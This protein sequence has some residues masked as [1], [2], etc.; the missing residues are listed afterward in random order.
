KGWLNKLYRDF[1]GQ[2]KR[3]KVPRGKKVEM[4]SG[5]G[6]IKEIIPGVITSDVVKAE[7]IDMIF[8]AERMPFKNGGVTAFY[9]LNTLHHIK[10][11]EKA[12]AE[13][14]RCLKSGGKV[15]MIEPANT[16]WSRIIYHFHQEVFDPGAD[17]RVDGQ[18]RLADSNIALPWIIFVR[19]RKRFAR[20]FP[21]LKVVKVAPQTPFLYLF[22]GGLSFPQMLPTSLYPILKWLEERLDR[23]RWRLGMFM[24]IELEKI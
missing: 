6:F 17:W 12:F 3:V 4:G 1:Y 13:M 20:L 5:A 18:N 7:G 2:M 23:W 14:D 22:S 21:G 8:F 15:V 10:N 19:D 24:A 9:M 16:W 11:V